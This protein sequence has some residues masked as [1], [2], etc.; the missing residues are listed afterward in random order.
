MNPYES[1]EFLTHM[2]KVDIITKKNGKRMKQFQRF[3]FRE[4][5]LILEKKV[6][7]DQY[8]NVALSRELPCTMWKVYRGRTGKETC[9]D[10]EAG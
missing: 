7:H 3:P 8:E 1:P 6:R 9:S 2:K 4:T 5:R 10:G